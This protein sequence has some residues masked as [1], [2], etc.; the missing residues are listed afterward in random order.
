MLPKAL[1]VVLF[2]L[3]SGTAFAQTQDFGGDAK[4]LRERI[5]AATS[6][7]E[8]VE[9]ATDLD[10]LRKVTF[11]YEYRL[12]QAKEWL[13]PA[14]VLRNG[15]LYG[16]GA[17][18]GTGVTLY[19]ATKVF[20]GNHRAGEFFRAH[21]SDYTIDVISHMPGYLSIAGT[22]YLAGA[23]FQQMSIADQRRE[24]QHLTDK[25]HLIREKA[26]LLLNTLLA[27]SSQLDGCT[28][29]FRL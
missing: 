15:F 20:R 19:L 12:N 25:L 18:M 1:F 26:D 21:L 8:L 27:K 14:T 10:A 7:D 17:M 22:G 29:P 23:A 28:I 16:Y 11:E 5:E 9:I 13:K 2:S 24:I 4:T 6:C 3:I